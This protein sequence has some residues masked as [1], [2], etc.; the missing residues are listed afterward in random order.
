[1]CKGSKYHTHNYT[2]NYVYVCCIY[3]YLGIVV[4]TN[5]EML[6]CVFVYCLRKT[7]FGVV[8]LVHSLC[9]GH[10]TYCFVIL[11][12]VGVFIYMYM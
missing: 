5:T 3:W 2:Q 6:A 8:K 11:S 12:D 10:P 4:L 7:V 9:P 1:M